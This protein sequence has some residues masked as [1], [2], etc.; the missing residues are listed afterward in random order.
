MRGLR[1]VPRPAARFGAIGLDIPERLMWEALVVRQD[2]SH[3]PGWETGRPSE[4][5]F[6]DMRDGSK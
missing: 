5:A 1:I 6:M 3:K 4:P 2:I